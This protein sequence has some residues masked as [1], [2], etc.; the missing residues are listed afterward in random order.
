MTGMR[1]GK[2]APALMERS[3]FKPL[4]L[5]GAAGAD[6]AFGN[7]GWI[8]PA[9]AQ[10][11]W[12]GTTVTA[13]M[14]DWLHPTAENLLFS[15]QNNLAVCQAKWKLLSVCLIWPTAG[16]ERD[17]SDMMRQISS[18][19]AERGVQVCGGDTLVSA[20]ISRPVLTLTGYGQAD[21]E[22]EHHHDVKP[23]QHILMAGCVGEAA[24]ALLANAFRDELSGRYPERLISLASKVR[25]DIAPAALLSYEQDCAAL[26]D[27]SRGG[28][29]GALWEL[30][31][32]M[33]C[34]FDIYLR[35]LPIRQETIEICEYLDLNP[36][37]LYGQGAL[38][39]VTGSSD[40]G[41]ALKLCEKLR[42]AG[43]PA[44]EIGVCTNSRA[45]RIL[46]GEEIRY[47]E[48]PAQDMLDM[49]ERMG[50]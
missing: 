25:C 18:F 14:G 27:V 23:G 39:I 48:K 4:H 22:A 34:G 46:N 9:G 37:Q 31:E 24:T 50:R 40:S 42:E 35:K 2:A 28:V 38:L 49:L 33:N 43:Y 6:A 30:G 41:D 15:I 21:R 7:D 45:R 11:A 19:C 17:L 1:S 10:Y 12:H 16:T 13:V 32:K 36:Y 47:L 26:H 5:A 44:E 8:L 20:D 3:V 29:F